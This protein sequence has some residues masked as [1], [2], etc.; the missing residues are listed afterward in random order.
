MTCR[1]CSC[2]QSVSTAFKIPRTSVPADCTV[3]SRP[4]N[5]Q[6]CINETPH[7]FL[8][9]LECNPPV[10][11]ICYLD[12]W[13]ALAVN[14]HYWFVIGFNVHSIYQPGTNIYK[15]LLMHLP[16][17]Q[18]MHSRI[19]GWTQPRRSALYLVCSSFV[20][21]LVHTS[22]CFRRSRTCVYQSGFFFFFF[23]FPFPMRGC[24]R[25][26]PALVSS[27]PSYGK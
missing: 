20:T 22:T 19:S 17:L 2:C 25:V 1:H 9:G 13:S 10:L 12:F 26:L 11:V 7:A 21:I 6:W 15:P 18:T 14:P 4:W 8:G 16:S 5:G 3:I 24:Y 23:A 27:D